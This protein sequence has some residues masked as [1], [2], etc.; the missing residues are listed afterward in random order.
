[1]R[2]I[3]QLLKYLECIFPAFVLAASMQIRLLS[4]Q[5]FDITKIIDTF[6]EGGAM[7]VKNIVVTI[8]GPSSLSRKAMI[9][10][11]VEKG[12]DTNVSACLLSCY[13]IWSMV[14]LLQPKKPRMW[15]Q[16][17]AWMVRL[18]A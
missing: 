10:M 2:C 6:K 12:L 4:L 11:T 15:V 7:R 9:G 3:S 5:T 18:L 14:H 8:L 16:H 13:Q 1:M 17:V